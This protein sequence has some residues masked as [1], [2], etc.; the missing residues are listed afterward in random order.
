M[1]WIQCIKDICLT[2][3]RG[4]I[5]AEHYSNHMHT[6]QKNWNIRKTWWLSK[7]EPGARKS[8]LSTIVNQIYNFSY[9][10][11]VINYFS[12]TNTLKC[13]GGG[14]SH[15]MYPGVCNIFVP[16]SWHGAQEPSTADWRRPSHGKDGWPPV[17]HP[18]TVTWS[19]PSLPWGLYGAPHQL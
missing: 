17:F 15:S 2:W 4:S 3:N 14:V 18:E 19:G 8:T 9:I 1:K 10:R 16:G 5:N 6:I 13:K 11:E 12:F 7:R